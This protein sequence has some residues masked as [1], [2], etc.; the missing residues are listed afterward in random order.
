MAHD[1]AWVDSVGNPYP[2]T[3]NGIHVADSPPRSMNAAAS[4]AQG[5]R[6]R[7][8]GCGAPAEG[9]PTRCWVT[10]M[11]LVVSRNP[12]SLRAVIDGLLFQMQDYVRAVL[13]LA[14]V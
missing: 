11:K 7:H 13:D 2:V 5:W 6:S 10:A 12:F 3:K 1:A 14:T 9:L 8:S 4:S